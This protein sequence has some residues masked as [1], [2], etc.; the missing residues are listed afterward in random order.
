MVVYTMV[1]ILPS[2]RGQVVERIFN[3]CEY[4]VLE[5]WIQNWTRDMAFTE[6]AYTIEKT[7]FCEHLGNFSS[8]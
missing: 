1:Y 5:R 4:S 3:G 7:I 2:K 8:P 6:Q